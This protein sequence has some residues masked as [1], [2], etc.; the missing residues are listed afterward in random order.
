MPDDLPIGIRVDAKHSE[1]LARVISMTR[2][3]SLEQLQSLIPVLDDYVPP[4]E[5]PP[6]NLEQPALATPETQEP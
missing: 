2:R 5:E 1:C 6:D 3:L 4:C